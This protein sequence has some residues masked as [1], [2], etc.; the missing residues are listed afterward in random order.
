MLTIKFCQIPIWQTVIITGYLPPWSACIQYSLYQIEGL[1]GHIQRG[2]ARLLERLLH[3]ETVHEEA[4]QR[5]RGTSPVGEFRVRLRAESHHDFIEQPFP[6]LPR[7]SSRT[8]TPSRVSRGT[9]PPSTTSRR[10]STR[11]WK[12]YRHETEDR[13]RDPAS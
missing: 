12:V 3:H 1:R 4:G 13:L 7:S 5:A 11:T 9:R 2:E 8:R 10:R 6:G